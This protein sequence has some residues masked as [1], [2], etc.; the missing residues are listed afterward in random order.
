M[1]PKHNFIFISIVAL[2]FFAIHSAKADNATISTSTITTLATST[3][4]TTATASTST[5]TIISMPVVPQ[6]ITQIQQ[7]K[8]QLASIIL[9]HALTAVYKNVKNKK[10]KKTTKT[11]AGYNLTSK[12]IVLAILDPATGNIITTIGRQSGKTMVFPGPEVQVKLKTFNGVNSKF[13]IDSPAGGVVL[14]LKYLI[15]SPDSG[16]KA[17]I[18]NGL[19]EAV[20]VPY[21][22]GL[23]DPAV[24][25]YGESYLN[26][27]IRNVADSLQNEPSAAMPGK[28]ITQAIPPAM[29]KALV[30]AEHTDTTQVLR[31]DVQDTVDQLNI[32]FA[33]NQGDAYKYSVSTASARGI[34]QFIPSTYASLVQRHPN[35]GFI[36]DFVQGMAD[37]TNSIKAMYVLLDDY[38]GAVRVKA[39]QG[40]AA[41]RIFEYAAASYNGGTARVANAVNTYGADWNSDHSGE[42]NTLQSQISSLKSQ[43]KKA[44]DKKTKSAL[45]GQL[46]TANSQLSD[47]QSATLRNET[48]NYLNKIYKVITMFND[49]VI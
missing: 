46:A 8:V 7:A 2:S 10:T 48:I 3:P 28:T 30:Y 16:S 23:S 34:A 27:I 41:G 11:L 31:G 12:D 15:S 39:A 32:L 6:L 44:K 49:Q 13:Q 33:T 42:I 35:L 9:N 43:I 47:L 29:I 45:Q 37:H 17:A 1:K 4:T 24:L 26:T 14:A 19:S 18:E 25:A 38:A 20:Y 40:F 5:S 21:S 22:S 36:P